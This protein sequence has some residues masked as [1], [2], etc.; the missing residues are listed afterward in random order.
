MK[1]IRELLLNACAYT[2]LILT[3]FFVFLSLDGS[4]HYTMDLVS[5]FSVFIMSCAISA[6]SLIFLIKGLKQ[7]YRI[8]IH[9]F[10][11]LVSILVMLGFTGYL[12]SKSPADY[13]VIILTYAFIYAAI[14]VC[15]YFI[16]KGSR[17]L[18]S[19]VKAIT[20]S[21]DK[22]AKKSNPKESNA[23]TDMEYTPRFR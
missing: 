7:V 8:I 16:K 4:S 9:A 15:S 12:A 2:V 1:K 14:S 22:N 19:R 6:S 11:L 20:S 10:A 13:F 21:K 5:F 23:K 18:D 3:L 17:K